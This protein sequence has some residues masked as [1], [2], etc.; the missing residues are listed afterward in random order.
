M[1]GLGVEGH[2]VDGVA[3][4][5]PPSH[6]TP[7]EA[8]AA[9]ERTGFLQGV[10]SLQPSTPRGTANGVQ[11]LGLRGCR[12]PASLRACASDEQDTDASGIYASLQQRRSQLTSRR[13]STVQERTLVAALVGGSPSSDLNETPLNA[14]DRTLMATRALR[15][16]WSG[17]EGEAAREAIELSAYQEDGEAIR[18]L[19]EL[20]E[21]YPDWAEPVNQLATL[22][23]REGDVT[24]SVKLYLRVMHM[25]PWHF[26]AIHGIQMSHVELGNMEEAERWGAEAMPRQGHERGKWVDRMLQVLDDKLA[27]LEELGTTSR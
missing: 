11:W 17:E 21:Q 7:S 3:A 24:E 6:C 1:V 2:K 9:G 27:I 4:G 5:E 19:E 12:T 8:H 22:R 25:K 14:E 18:A 26:G 20:M 16:H 15:H 23:Y 13:D 10:G